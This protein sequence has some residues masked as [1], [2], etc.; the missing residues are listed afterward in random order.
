MVLLV[1]TEPTMA[2][3]ADRDCVI[4]KS[5]ASDMMKLKCQR[6][7]ATAKDTAGM[8]AS[9]AFKSA[10]FAPLSIQFTLIH[11]RSP[12]MMMR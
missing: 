7:V 3:A 2:I 9:Q 10:L 11:P 6:I 1:V 5:L 8:V 12:Q 4:P